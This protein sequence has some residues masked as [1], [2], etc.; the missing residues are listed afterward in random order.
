MLKKLQRYAPKIHI[1]IQE[2]FFRAPQ[3]PK[4]E[5]SGIFGLT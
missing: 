3:L 4:L 2:N 5:V 1:L